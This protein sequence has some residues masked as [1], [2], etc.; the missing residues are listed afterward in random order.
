MI[1]PNRFK[2]V[3]LSGYVMSVINIENEM[4]SVQGAA[5]SET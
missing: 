1:V 4:K 2:D 5:Y 3:R